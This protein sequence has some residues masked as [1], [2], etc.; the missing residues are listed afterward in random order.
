MAAESRYFLAIVGFAR[1]KTRG[2]NRKA[3][4]TVLIRAFGRMP[5]FQ[6]LEQRF[7]LLKLRSAPL[8]S[9]SELEIT[10]QVTPTG[11]RIHWAECRITWHPREGLF[12]REPLAS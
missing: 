9:L 11:P 2:S 5:I 7:R 4:L 8:L 10:H 1:Q 12:P 6:S 3:G